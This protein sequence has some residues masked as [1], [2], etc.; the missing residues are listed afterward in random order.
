MLAPLTEQ[1]NTLSRHDSP[2]WNR[3]GVVVEEFHGV[4]VGDF[5]GIWAS[6]RSENDRSNI[7]FIEDLSKYSVFCGNV[8]KPQGYLGCTCLY[9]DMHMSLCVWE[10]GMGCCKP[11]G[12]I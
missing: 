1:D 2:T 6:L 9:V 12:F 8:G 11:T 5:G 4:V 10:G 7:V 3:V